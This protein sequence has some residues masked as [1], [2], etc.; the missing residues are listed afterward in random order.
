MIHLLS[1][2]CPIGCEAVY[3]N[4]SGTQLTSSNIVKGIRDAVDSSEEL[5]IIDV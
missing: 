5:I 2:Y 3:N 4:D 1:M